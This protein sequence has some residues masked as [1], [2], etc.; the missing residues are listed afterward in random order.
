MR[1]LIGLDPKGV[2]TPE[3]VNQLVKLSEGN[4]NFVVKGFV[5]EGR[6]TFHP[7]LFMIESGRNLTFLT[8]SHN[9]TDSAFGKNVE[10]GVQ[11]RCTTGEIIGH[12]TLQTF[13]S[14]WEDKR[15]EVVDADVAKSYAEACQKNSS[16]DSTET[17]EE[18]K[19]WQ[20]FKESLR[21]AIP[22]PEWP[23]VDL[24]YLMGVIYARGKFVDEKSRVQINLTIG[25]GGKFNL[26][27]ESHKN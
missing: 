2:K 21:P 6:E 26:L 5:P 12:K 14:L 13:N 1:F 15:S 3:A 19:R 11:V 25:A 24:A 27:G 10:F 22:L 18:S 17:S 4:E 9:L 16:D 20:K 7:K 23:S 8:G